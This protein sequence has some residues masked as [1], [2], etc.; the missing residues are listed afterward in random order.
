MTLAQSGYIPGE[1]TRLQ[2][3]WPGSQTRNN[4]AEVLG[5]SSSHDQVSTNLSARETGSR[6]NVLQM[7]GC[8]WLE[9]GLA[10]NCVFSA[11][12]WTLST[13]KPGAVLAEPFPEASRARTRSR[14]GE[15]TPKARG[16][17]RGPSQEKAKRPPLLWDFDNFS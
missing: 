14:T 3:G 12:G 10:V 9:R 5:N 16:S 1:G 7:S 17:P 4:K 6:C 13:A 11:G 8:T 2:F 15:W